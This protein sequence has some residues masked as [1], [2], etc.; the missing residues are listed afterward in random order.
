[1][2]TE[3]EKCSFCECD[4][5]QAFAV[6]VGATVY[7]VLCAE[8]G[9]NYLFRCGLVLASLERPIERVFVASLIVR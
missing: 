4:A 3:P 7:A 8:H 1:M 5:D 2:S 9:A 6:R